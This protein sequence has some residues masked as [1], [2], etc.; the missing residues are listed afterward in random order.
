MIS[1]SF[2]V[3]WILAVVPLAFFALSTTAGAASGIVCDPQTLKKG[4][5]LT[6]TFKA[7]PHPVEIV[8]NGPNV[9]KTSGP[10]SRYIALTPT[11]GGAD[12]GF[13]ALSKAKTL[14][15]RD[16]AALPKFGSAEADNGPYKALSTFYAPGQYKIIVGQNLETDDGT[17]RYGTCTVSYRP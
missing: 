14:E 15:L 13:T 1:T 8:I 9:P 7:A 5:T 4:G 10:S 3:P 11:P 16:S 2:P 6:V 12:N 17:P